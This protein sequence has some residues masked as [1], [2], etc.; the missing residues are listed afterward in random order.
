MTSSVPVDVIEH[1]A[2]AQRRFCAAIGNLDDDAVRRDS[3]LPGWSVAHVL[4]HVS[5]NAD[6]HVR[7]AEAAARGD[8]V[9]QY[10]GGYIGR[11]AEIESTA[12][13]PAATLI[14]DVR[15]SADQLAFAWA[16]VPEAAWP[17][18]TIDVGGRERAL[19]ELPSRR[20]QEL[21]VHVIDLDLGVTHREW[22]DDFVAAW[23]PRLRA[24]L[25]ERLAD[26]ARPPAGGTLDERDEL[27]W[28]YGRL[29]RDDLPALAP[30][31]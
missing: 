22:S 1:V 2:D 24:S 7:R 17:M 26:G 9:E 12:R 19:A 28:L 3:L 13:R 15:S 11:A 30:W 25:S 5:R 20:W 10:A 31:R 18:V 23:L 21:E 14:A 16:S 29:Q 8:V 27:A 6:S 4:A